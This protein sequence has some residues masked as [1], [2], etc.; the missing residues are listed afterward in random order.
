MDRRPRASWW[1][2][3]AGA[4][5]V[6]AL[7]WRL[8]LVARLAHT[9]L[10][11]Q[12]DAD[13]ETYWGW[14]GLLRAHGWLGS[15]PFFMAP[16]Y[17][18]WLAVV[19]IVVGD[20]I[21]HVLQ[22]QALLGAAAAVL[23]A[24]AAR[25]LT[26][27]GW[28]VVVGVLAAGYQTSGLYTL[29][30]LSEGLLFALGAALV[31]LFVAWPWRARPGLGAVLA[32]ALV[33]TLA[34]GRAIAV[35]L[36]VPLAVVLIGET[37]RRRAVGAWAAAAATVVVLSLPVA[38]RHEALVHEWIP[39]TYGLGFNLYVGNGPGAN[40]TYVVLADYAG[41]PAADPADQEGGADGD[42]RAALA[43]VRGLE[44]SPAQ[45]SEFWAREALAA[46]RAHPGRALRLLA[47][48]LGTLLNR[49]EVPQIEDARAY[50]SV[51]GPLGLPVGGSFAFA[52]PLALLGCVVALRRGPRARALVAYAS[53]LALATAA[54][55][56][57][58][59]YRYQLVPALLP[60]VA[61]A[62]S[63]LAHGLRA[64]RRAGIAL[65]TGALAAC[66]G[67]VW[68]PLVPR[69]PAHEK[70]GAHLMMGE[71]WMRASEPRRALAEFD[72]AVALD[73]SGRMR[74]ADLPEARRLRAGAFEDRGLAQWAVGRRVA[75]IASFERA[76]ELAPGAGAMQVMLGERAAIAGLPAESRT[77]FD[78]V[79]L[80]PAQASS[81]LVGR[82][83]RTK[84]GA[85]AIE[86]ELRGALTLE[87]RNEEAAVALVRLLALTGRPDSAGA[88][89]ERA[90]AR[91]L[92][93]ALYA[94]HRA[95][96]A[97]I[98]GRAGEAAAWRG[99]VP[100]AAARD[101][102]V[103]ATL[104]LERAAGAARGAPAPP[105]RTPPPSSA[106]PRPPGGR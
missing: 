97:T 54:F 94:A 62:L 19:R 68:L 100:A 69:D 5:F 31:W 65:A 11:A 40:G 28:G 77:A 37:T 56:V 22:V 35:L 83:R 15:R 30:V 70:W 59:R 33:G 57:T 104:Q 52:G 41:G 55:F 24:D 93:P 89:L 14:A 44:L 13:A 26:S 18:Y 42:T 74:N 91:G 79:G 67:V 39:Y 32:G 73:A 103:L 101:A 98:S 75:A 29:L 36:L 17:P 99:R 85:A 21:L 88:V 60:L 96:V 95:L 106:Q 47:R 23:L 16:L 45:S 92:A 1:P 7:A 78:H 46:V 34:H 71:A 64:P 82:A 76:A 38:M 53:V 58:D 27:P 72:A 90:R 9:P 84:S 25:R 48:K 50:A 51:L 81:V 43:R 4:V 3:A 80:D 6:A 61:V 105:P 66:A 8:W 63:W 2:V 10:I 12:L 87:P 86:G 102:R 49:E 20:S